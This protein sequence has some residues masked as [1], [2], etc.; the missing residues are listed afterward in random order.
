MGAGNRTG[1][2]SF[3]V[4]LRSLGTGRRPTLKN[5]DDFRAP[6]EKIEKC[7]RFLV[8]RGVTCHVTPFGLGC[9]A[10]VETFETLFKVKLKAGGPVRGA[11]VFQI[12]GT[13]RT[14]QEIEE[15]VEQVTLTVEPEFL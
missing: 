6:A 8:G 9:S 4:L 3:D 10:P 14:P 11:P 5:I 7:K 2:L 13:I 12:E 1:N 15:L